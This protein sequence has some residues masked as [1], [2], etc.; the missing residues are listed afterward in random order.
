MHELNV[1][2]MQFVVSTQKRFNSHFSFVFSTGLYAESHGFIQNMM[3][4][5]QYGDLFLMAPNDTASL[6]HWWEHAEPLWVTAEK[7]NIKSALY[8]WDG[9]QV[10][11]K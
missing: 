1:F 9:C 11:N 8:W 4:D 5:S 10:K 2:L 7:H 6:K 3:Y